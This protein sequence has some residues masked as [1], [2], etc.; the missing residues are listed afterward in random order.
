MGWRVWIALVAAVLLIAQGFTPVSANAAGPTAVVLDAFGN[1]I[2]LAGYIAEGLDD[3]QRGAPP[4]CCAIH[5]CASTFSAGVLPKSAELIVG[6]FLE[7]PKQD[8]PVSPFLLAAD[9][10]LPG[11]PRAPP[12]SA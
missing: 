3:S 12:F 4:D 6:P 8:L 2:C 1:P 7:L 11:N 10:Y 5:C 9:G